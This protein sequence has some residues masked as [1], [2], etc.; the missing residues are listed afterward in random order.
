MPAE[1][2]I[3]VRCAELMTEGGAKKG[4]DGDGATTMQLLVRYA[5]Y[6][7]DLPL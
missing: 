5:H 3:H 2:V 1:V 4:S 6:D 7:A